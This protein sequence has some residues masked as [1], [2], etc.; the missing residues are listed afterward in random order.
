MQQAKK[1]EEYDANT[2]LIFAPPK[3]LDDEE[4]GFLEGVQKREEERNRSLAELEEKEL[5]FETIHNVKD[6]DDSNKS[7]QKI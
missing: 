4:I 2:K 6:N 3:A 5:E 7:S 1:K